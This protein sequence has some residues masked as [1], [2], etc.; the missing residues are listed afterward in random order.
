MI[1]RIKKHTTCTL[2]IRIHPGKTQ[3]K[4]VA[5]LCAFFLEIYCKSS[6]NYDDNDD[7]DATPWND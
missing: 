1:E 2:F 5:R 3:S 4:E 6:E 7:D